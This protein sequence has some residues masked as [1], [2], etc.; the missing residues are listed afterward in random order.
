M[1][2]LPTAGQLLEADASC[3]I[4]HSVGH[5]GVSL[6]FT[7]ISPHKHAA[8]LLP[9]RNI[10]SQGV[11]ACSRAHLRGGSLADEAEVAVA[12]GQQWQVRPHAEPPIAQ[13]LA[14]Q[15]RL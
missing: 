11:D 15:I 3:S 10:R 7:S 6:Q 2:L 5:H 8:C 14:C 13:G 4:A 12:L 1:L 9:C